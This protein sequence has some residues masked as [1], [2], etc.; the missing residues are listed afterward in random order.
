MS[1]VI[2]NNENINKLGAKWFPQLKK[3]K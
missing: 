3:I 1:C 2:D